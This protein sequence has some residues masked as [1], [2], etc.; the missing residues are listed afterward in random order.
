[1]NDV[2]TN[3]E[4]LFKEVMGSYPSGVTVV[5]TVD[6]NNQPVGLTANSFV[7]VSID[8]LLILWCIDKKSTSYAAFEHSDYF[9]VNILS[10]DQGDACWAFA[11]KKEP[12][13]FSKC[14]WE[15][16]ENKVPVIK[17]AF[18][19]LECKKYN[20]VDAGD[21]YILIGQV[22]NIHKADKEA[23]LYY[24]RNLGAVPESFGK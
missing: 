20:V 10:A 21:H 22:V 5:T 19:N 4:Q 8:P 6:A 3:T 24:K 11:S 17:N 15:L 9:T 18:A 2:Q 14:S 1:M 16:S 13:R 7:S 23:M 12:D